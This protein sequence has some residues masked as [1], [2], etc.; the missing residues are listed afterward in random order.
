MQMVCLNENA[1]ANE[2]TL[3]T[4]LFSD[5]KK[6]SSNAIHAGMLQFIE[7]NAVSRNQN[8]LKSALVLNK[9]STHEK[10]EISKDKVLIK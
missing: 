6:P 3:K 5:E 8:N 9:Y 7:K 4:S 10:S 1:P 2:L